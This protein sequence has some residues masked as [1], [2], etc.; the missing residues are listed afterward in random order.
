MPARHLA[1]ALEHPDASARLQSALT[2]GTHPDPAFL[3]PLVSRCA[4]E[5]DFYVREM[6][7][8]ALTRL[9]HDVVVRRIT[10]ELDSAIPQARSQAL[11]TLSKLGDER[12]WA[13]I[14]TAHLHDADEEVARTAWRAA[15]VLAPEAERTGLA[16]ELAQELG[17]GGFELQRS[18]ARAL[19]GLG[20]GGREV[21]VS[22][23]L[24]GNP[25]VREH[26]AA[27]L[28]LFED[29]ESTFF[30]AALE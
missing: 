1:S 25:S 17:R 11:H 13:A 30:L 3:D 24:F 27:T 12:S 26:A 2:A 18:L 21:A 20:A 6:L 9:P 19:V 22:A 28:R 29:P 8:W 23:S 5:P 14:T 10:A 7:T 4:I 15:V 16:R